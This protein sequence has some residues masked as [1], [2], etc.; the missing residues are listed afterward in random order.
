LNYFSC[1]KTWIFT[2]NCEAKNEIKVIHFTEN[3]I[4]M[5][6]FISEIPPHKCVSSDLRGL[7]N[8]KFS[9]LSAPTM[10]ALPEILN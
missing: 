2:R 9:G 3:L 7:E 5:S 8:G 10:G 1:T 4:V 6:N